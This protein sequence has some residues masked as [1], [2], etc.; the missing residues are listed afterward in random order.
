VRSEVEG[1]GKPVGIRGYRPGWSKK[2]A[3]DGVAGTSC[4]PGGSEKNAVPKQRDLVPKFATALLSARSK[5]KAQ[6]QR[7]HQITHLI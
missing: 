2:R 7:K 4:A 3:G 6:Q 1:G 5:R